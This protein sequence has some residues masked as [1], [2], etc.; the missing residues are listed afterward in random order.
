MPTSDGARPVTP[1]HARLS[2]RALLIGIPGAAALGA[3]AYLAWP[4]DDRADR[5]APA[6]PAPAWSREPPQGWGI[7]VS[8]QIHGA[9]VIVVGKLGTVA[10][11]DRATGDPL[12]TRDLR[13]QLALNR[14]PDGIGPAEV[15][16]FGYVAGDAIALRRE[17][18]DEEKSGRAM[19]EL[20]IAD[21]ATGTTRGV[22]GD[23]GRPFT[24][25]FTDD[26]VYTIR[27]VLEGHGT[28]AAYDLADGRERWRREPRGEFL[29]PVQPRIGLDVYWADQSTRS[30]DTMAVAVG[31]FGLE[32]VVGGLGEERYTETTAYGLATGEPLGTWRGAYRGYGSRLIVGDRLVRSSQPFGG[33][34]VLSGVDPVTGVILWTTPTVEGRLGSVPPPAFADGRLFD[35]PLL[36]KPNL[37]V[38]YGFVDLVTGTAEAIALPWGTAVLA[39]HGGVAATLAGETGV[40]S[41]VRTADGTQAWSKTLFEVEPGADGFVPTTY[42]ADGP[43]LAVS[44]RPESVE[45]VEQYVE[46]TW[47]ADIATGSVRTIPGVTVWGLGEGALVTGGRAEEGGRAVYELSLY[48]LAAA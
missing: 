32:L 18:W 28:V 15:S 4:A 46:R 23:G 37:P 48:E 16:S 12:W 14:I 29:L 10:V 11:L 19:R 42:R 22:I 35:A 6:S 27:S 8:V 26:A 17:K 45:R 13:D 47:I 21:L 34:P 24:P 31:T 7:P 9:Y 30:Q 33:E 3:A 36:G 39:A 41:G 2:R 44:G 38:E 20:E 5:D 1:F 25:M 43:Y 40:L